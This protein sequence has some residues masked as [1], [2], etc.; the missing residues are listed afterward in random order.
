M[1]I[2]ILIRY[3]SFIVALI[4]F[5]SIILH[6]KYRRKNI[7][8]VSKEFHKQIQINKWLSAI[9]WIGF[10]VWI[11]SFIVKFFMDMNPDNVHVV[12]CI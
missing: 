9:M 7:S 12:I 5:I 3:I 6:N 4:A 2:I 11:L 8:L 10:T 1:N